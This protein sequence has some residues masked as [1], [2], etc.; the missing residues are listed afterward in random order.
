MRAIVQRVRSA[1]VRVDEKIVGAIGP[2][3]LVYLGVGDEDGPQDVQYISRK[4]IGL[5]VFPDERHSMNLALADVSGE[6]LVVSQFTLYGDC[7]RGR[8][9][10]FDKAMDPKPASELIFSVCLELKLAGVQTAQGRFGAMMDVESS[11][12]GPVTILLDSKKLF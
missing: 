7:R 9:P 4:I 3:F 5:R 8:R 10:S 6:V 11:N 12:W 1:C 2:G